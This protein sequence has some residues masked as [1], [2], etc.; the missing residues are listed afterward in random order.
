MKIAFFDSGLGG[1]SVLHEARLAL[2][3]EQFIFYADED[4]VP[5]G[6]KTRAEV[7]G[8]VAQAFDFLVAQDVKAIVVA[9]NTATS[10]AVAE[11]RHRYSIP[12]S[13]HWIWTGSTVCW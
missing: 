5:Y 11:M 2:P 6:T 10:V 12:I 1:L 8:F 9:C 4:H 3:G 7:Q 13:G